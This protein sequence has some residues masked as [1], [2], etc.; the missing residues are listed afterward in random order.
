MEPR[1]SGGLSGRIGMRSG[2]S[3][4]VELPPVDRPTAPM[5]AH[6]HRILLAQDAAAEGEKSGRLAEALARR[7]DALLDLVAVVDG[8]S[9]MFLRKNR[10]LERDPDRYLRA[11]EASLEVRVALCRSRGIRCVGSLVV[12][13]PALELARHAAA[14]HADLIVL[15]TSP[16]V[17]RR[18]QGALHFRALFLGGEARIPAAGHAA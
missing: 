2:V 3:I 17:V 12:G 15:A 16:E 13:A 14:T 5:V 11:I 7:S 6:A 1:T 18:V 9:E 4:L 10:A 8:F